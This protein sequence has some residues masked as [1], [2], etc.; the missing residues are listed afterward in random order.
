MYITFIL[1]PIMKNIYTIVWVIWIFIVSAWAYLINQDSSNTTLSAILGNEQTLLDYVPGELWQVLVLKADDDLKQVAQATNSFDTEQF[2]SVFNS[3]EKI[4]V[5]QNAQNDLPVNLL[6]IEWDDT[7]DISVLEELWLV[8]EGE[9][10]EAR[11]LNDSMI[12]YADTW[13]LDRYDTT[14]SRFVDQ[15]LANQFIKEYNEWDYNAWFFSTPEWIEELGWY[16][17]LV[18]WNLES[19][20]LLSSLNATTPQWKLILQMKNG[21]IATPTGTFEPQLEEYYSNSLFYLELQAIKDFLWIDESQIQTFLPFVAG[22]AWIPLPSPDG[23]SNLLWANLAVVLQPSTSSPLGIQASLIV[24]WNEHFQTLQVV[25]PYLQQLITQNLPLIASWATLET[26]NT[27]DS[28]TT[29]LPMWDESLPV[30]SLTTTNDTTQLTILWSSS[31]PQTTANNDVVADNAVAVFGRDSTLLG[32][33]VGGTLPAW[34]Q[35][36]TLNG[37]IIVNDAQDQIIVNFLQT[38]T[39]E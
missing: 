17:A 6:F 8:A 33:L 38:T 22:T 26:I 5:Y 24:Q 25:Y 29:A 18:A 16:S 32:Q 11:E 36:W 9:D 28:I 2:A 13:G 31:T 19:T 12:V 30:L 15:S 23:I 35:S 1:T 7:F 14:T 39:N 20:Y 21:T 34:V 37:S 10:F 4:I 3:V 27:T